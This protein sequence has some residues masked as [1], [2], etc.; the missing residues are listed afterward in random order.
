M[1]K[2]KKTELKTVPPVPPSVWLS[3]LT[4]SLMG[5]ALPLVM[6]QIFDRIIPFQATETLAVLLLGMLIVIPLEMLQKILRAAVLN[7]QAADH[8]AAL[9]AQIAHRVLNVSHTAK[10]T[11][12]PRIH[13]YLLSASKVRDNLCGTGRLYLIELPFAFVGLGL[14][15]LLAGPL[16][17]VPLGGFTL[18]FAVATV[19]RR[20]HRRRLTLREDADSR[21]YSLFQQLI[22]HPESVKAHQFEAGLNSRYRKAQGRAARASQ[23]VFFSSNLFQSLAQSIN[24]FFSAA[25]VCAGA[26]LVLQRQIGA[27]ELAACTMLNG[28][29]AQPLMNAVQQWTSGESYTKS[30]QVVA[31]AMA[32]PQTPELQVPV[33]QLTS[34]KPKVVFDNVTLRAS[35]SGRAVLRNFSMRCEEEFVTLTAGATGHISPVF[36]CLMGQWEAEQGSVRINGHEAATLARFRGMG[37]VIYINGTP[38]IFEG[39]LIFNIALSDATE[40]VDRAY[41]AAELLG[42]DQD[43]NKLPHGYESD[44]RASGIML[45]SRG[46]MQRIN[47]ARAMA[48]QP[49]ILLLDDAMSAMDTGLQLRTAAALQRFGR[50]RLILAYDSSHVLERFSDRTVSI[51][52]PSRRRGGQPHRAVSTISSAPHHRSDAA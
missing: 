1:G 46:F 36:R 10:L 25:I 33:E 32:L 22:S 28:R 4:L 16:V 21:R 42:L 12:L 45:S 6:L 15:W 20:I 14:I 26:Y 51:A 41:H 38:S 35:K 50:E 19:V 34:Q 18:L 43:V 48:H 7:R 11:D 8:G 30:R 40:A 44:M 5:L 37:G 52:A 2:S 39:T 29:A 3:T 23:A 9:S 31:E 27:A 47:I 17:L 24:L 13:M 49:S